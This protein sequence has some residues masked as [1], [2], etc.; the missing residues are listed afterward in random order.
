MKSSGC[1]EGSRA[2]AASSVD[3]INLTSCSYAFIYFALVI[4]ALR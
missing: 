2:F 3:S 1:L 4:E